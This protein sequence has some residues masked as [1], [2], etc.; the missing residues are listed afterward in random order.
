VYGDRRIS[1]AVFA[2]TATRLAHALR[3]SGVEPGDRVAYLM[4]N[5]PELLI[6]HFGVPLAGAVLVAINIRLAAAE[7]LHLPPLRSQA[8]GRRFGSAPS[9]RAGRKRA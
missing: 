3:A 4:P 8:A 2:A 6:A 7:I 1:Y 5:I 9:D